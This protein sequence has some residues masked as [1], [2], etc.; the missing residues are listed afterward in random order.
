ME[1]PLS[2]IIMQLLLGLLHPLAHLIC[3]PRA[4][5]QLE[6][7]RLWS[8]TGTEVI[9]ITHRVVVLAVVVGDVE[10]TGGVTCVAPGGGSV[11]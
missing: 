3:F 5:H 1:G 9:G 11:V 8:L 7:E 4:L 2:L 10:C 6:H